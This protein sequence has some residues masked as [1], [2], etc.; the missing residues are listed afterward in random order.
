M[1]LSIFI[2]M[3]IYELVESIQQFNCLVYLVPVLHVR[4][5]KC[6][7]NGSL[8]WWWYPYIDLKNELVNLLTNNIKSMYS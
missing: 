5:M 1:V 3:F 8:G 2:P 7:D 4:V 6:R